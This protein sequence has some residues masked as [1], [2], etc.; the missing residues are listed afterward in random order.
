MKEIKFPLLT[1]DD[2]ELRIGQMSKDGTKASLLLYQDARCGMK[3]LDQ[4]VGVNWQKRYYEVRGLV[5]CSLGIY[6]DDTKQ[7][8][9]KD[10]T[11]SSGT[12]EEEKSIVSDSFKRCCVCWGLARELYTAPQIWVNVSSK[13]DKFYVKEI[14]YNEN[15]EINRLVITD[16]KGNEVYSYGVGAKSGYNKPKSAEKGNVTINEVSS[17]VNSM[18][19][20]PLDNEDMRVI[21]EYYASLN[22]TKKDQFSAWLFNVVN[23]TDINKLSE[24]QASR[25][26]NTLR[27][28]QGK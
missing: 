2:I 21:K 3:Y 10:D 5:I 9:W 11:G 7:W 13:Y 14:G 12:I 28:A 8:L 16:N 26:A 18:E 6:D 17:S 1:K 4:V 23:E 27:K 25:V 22:D 20:T 24:S 15:R 19:E